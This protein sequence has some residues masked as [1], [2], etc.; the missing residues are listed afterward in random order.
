[1]KKK[2]D[3]IQISRGLAA[4]LVIFYHLAPTT[5]KYFHVRS[6]NNFFS[7]GKIGVDFFFVLSGF[8][9]TFI[10]YK[11]IISSDTNWAQF[12]KKRFIRI[13]PIYW[14]VATLTFLIYMLLMK[15]NMRDEFIFDLGSISHWLY[16][17]KQ[18]LLLPQEAYF[19]PVAWS[20]SFELLF[21]IIFAICIVLGSRI[22][23]IIGITWFLLIVVNYWANSPSIFYLSPVIIEF[24]I[25]CIVGYLFSH[26]HY[27]GTKLFS[28]CLIILSFIGFAYY[29]YNDYHYGGVF[30]KLYYGCIFGLIIWKLATLDYFDKLLFLKR[31]ILKLI[32]DA[33]YSIYL[34]HP[35][36]LSFS[37]KV[38][39]QIFKKF[40]LPGYLNNVAFLLVVI[41]AI[42]GGILL[43]IV[44]EK[45]LINLFSRQL[46]KR[47]TV[48]S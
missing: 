1:M 19:V 47:P 48:Q 36:I 44:V 45:R 38:I 29:S 11:D 21:Y 34:I 23:K 9:I 20:L 42:A 3:L 31:N 5:E 2:L 32:G 28:I 24:L 22:A 8:I 35:I 4:I 16:L 30:E 7:F 27:L 6:F 26:S 17:M 15:G 10:H 41:C 14:V 40:N 12:L 46:L 18:Y 37:C 13:Y 39:A 25:G 33:S 43:H